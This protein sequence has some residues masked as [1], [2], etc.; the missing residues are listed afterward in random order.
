VVVDDN[1]HPVGILTERDIV[2]LLDAGISRDTALD[3]FRKPLVCASGERTLIFAVNIMLDRNIRRI[4]VVDAE[5][6][7]A[8]SFTQDEIVRHLEDEIYYAQAKIFHVLYNRRA[9]ITLPPEALLSEAVSLMAKHDVGSVVMLDRGVGSR[10]RHEK[11]VVR[12]GERGDES[13]GPPGRRHVAAGHHEFPRHIGQRRAANHAREAHPQGRGRRQRRH[14]LGIITSRDLLRN[15]EGSYSEFSQAQAPPRERNP[16][17]AAR[18]RAGSRR[19]R[20]G[21]A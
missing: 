12:L 20:P 2:R 7:L 8:A 19:R 14:A 6:G 3:A 4:V 13:L 21:R 10:H 18:N 15:A 1:G 11:D 5:G 16:R 9:L 17:C